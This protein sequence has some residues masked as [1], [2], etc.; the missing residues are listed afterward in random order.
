MRCPTCNHEPRPGE[1][2][3]RPQ[4]YTVFNGSNVRPAEIDFSHTRELAQ[5]EVVHVGGMPHEHLGGGVVGT[6]TEPSPE[7]PR[8]T[9]DVYTRHWF[10]DSCAKDETHRIEDCTVEV[11][12]PVETVPRAALMWAY[13]RQKGADSIVGLGCCDDYLDWEREMLAMP[14]GA[15]AGAAAL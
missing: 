8:V 7:L 6:N 4:T 5:G 11:P 10:D 9:G 12:E 13:A 2:Y 14:V 15:C 1:T 3:G